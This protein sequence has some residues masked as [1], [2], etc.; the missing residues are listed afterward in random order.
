MILNIEATTFLGLGVWTVR[1]LG[2]VETVIK[3]KS[4]I[5]LDGILHVVLPLCIFLRG[6]IANTLYVLSGDGMMCPSD[7]KFVL[8]VLDVI[9]ASLVVVGQ[10]SLADGWVRTVMN[11]F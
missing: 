4:L 8:L 1:R 7:Q 10:L 3:V 11:T 2:R 9:L 6:I 5:S